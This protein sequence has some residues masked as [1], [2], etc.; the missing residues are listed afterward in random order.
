[1]DPSLKPWEAAFRDSR[2]FT[3][4]WTLQELIAPPLVEFFSSNGIRLGDKK[5]L[6]IQLH[7]ITGI[8]VLA[9]RGR[10][11]SDFGFSERVL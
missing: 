11:I 4:G 8:P 3:R 9:L 1:M 2:W 5:T 6:E 7:Q 10:P